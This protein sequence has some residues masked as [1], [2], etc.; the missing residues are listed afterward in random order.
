LFRIVAGE[1]NK[2][3]LSTHPP[4][5]PTGWPEDYFIVEDLRLERQRP[6]AQNH[7]WVQTGQI[8]YETCRAP[9]EDS[10]ARHDLLRNTVTKLD[11]ACAILCVPADTCCFSTPGIADYWRDFHFVLAN[12]CYL[13]DAKPGSAGYYP[14]VIRI[15]GKAAECF[16]QRTN[17]VVV[18]SV[19]G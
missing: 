10:R 16:Q 12:G 9:N 17:K 11:N 5:L 14:S 6:S 8:L 19:E 13:L 3:S 7:E 2:F 1:P 4:G 18:Q 15:K